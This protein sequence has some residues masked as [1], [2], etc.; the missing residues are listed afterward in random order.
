VHDRVDPV[1]CG[2]HAPEPVESNLH[3]LLGEVRRTRALLGIAT[4]GDGD[5]VALVDERG[6]FVTPH[7]V[8]ALLLVHLVRRKGQRGRVVKT[9]SGSYLLDR[10]ARA[11]GLDVQETPVGFKYICKG[12]MSG[13]VLIGGEESGGVGVRGYIPERDGL[14]IGLLAL[15]MLAYARRP[16]SALIADLFR[17]FGASSYARLDAHHEQAQASLRRL[18]ASPPAAVAGERVARVNTL[19]GLKLILG[20]DA[21]VLF[22]ASGTEPLLRVYSESDSPARTRR[23]L[24]G[25]AKL[26]GV[27]R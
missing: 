14:Y 2:L 7:L 12:L 3:A 15:E 8:F 23:L 6:R 10:I 26:A 22:R 1:F 18:I 16:C 21:W 27:R 5:R 19:D 20:D 24:A 11:E 9:V 13:E 4:D 17:E 25:G